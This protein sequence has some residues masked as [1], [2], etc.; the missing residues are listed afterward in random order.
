MENGKTL[1]NDGLSKDFYEVFWDDV[2]I[3]LLTS[4]N[5]AFTKEG[6][7]T[8]QKE[9]LIKLVEIKCRGERFINNWRLISLLNTY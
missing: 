4:I 3:P 2:K 6:L 9:V 8:S 5:D 7:N 1:D